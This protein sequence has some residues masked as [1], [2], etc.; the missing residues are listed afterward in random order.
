MNY[1]LDTNA[2]IAFLRQR[3]SLIKRKLATIGFHS[4]VLCAPV[5]AELYYGAQ[6][7]AKPEANQRILTEFFANFV[8]LPFNDQ[9][10]EE[11]GRVRAQVERQGEPIGPYDLMIASIAPANNVTLVTHN[12][13]EFGRISGL[14]I[15]DWEVS[16]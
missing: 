11:Y 4:V 15:E 9:A 7:S 5:K 14:Q 1:L 13:R 12:T 8:S 3:E 2:C 6:R 10:A 16:A